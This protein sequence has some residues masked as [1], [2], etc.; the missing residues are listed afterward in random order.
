MNDLKEIKETVYDLFQGLVAKLEEEDQVSMLNYILDTRP[1]TISTFFVPS[2]LRRTTDAVFADALVR[3]LIL[4]LSI[5]MRQHT[6]PDT[7][8]GIIETI[9][10]SYLWSPDG[11]HLNSFMPMEVF[12]NLSIGD[13]GHI[14]GKFT[15][16]S[17]VKLALESNAWLLAYYL[18][19]T[20]E[21][22]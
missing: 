7:L 5:L 2:M 18:L 13:T 6:D 12:N 17:V 11:T 9:S 19:I 10:A 21:V 3:D 4:D 16:Y 1:K 15:S 14:N 8:A 20:Q 22:R